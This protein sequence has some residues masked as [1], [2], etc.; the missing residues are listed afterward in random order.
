LP[1]RPE[2]PFFFMFHLVSPRVSN[3]LYDDMARHLLTMSLWI[4][5]NWIT[6][7][8]GLLTC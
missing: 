4:K 1:C 8:V 6:W 7:L 5:L 2:P 3:L